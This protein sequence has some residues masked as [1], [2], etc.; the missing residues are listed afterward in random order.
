MRKESAAATAVRQDIPTPPAATRQEFSAQAIAQATQ[1]ATKAAVQAAVQAASQ[2]AAEAA[3]KAAAEAVSQ[4]TALVATQMAQVSRQVEEQLAEIR[5]QCAAMQL[6]HGATASEATAAKPPADHRQ[7]DE[8]PPTSQLVVPLG[9]YRRPA[10]FDEFSNNTTAAP[11]GSAVSNGSLNSSDVPLHATT[12]TTTQQQPRGSFSSHTTYT[13]RHK[14]Y[15]LPE[16]DGKPEDWPIFEAEFNQTTAEYGY[17]DAQN[18]SRLR[19]SLRG[20]AR[21]LVV[22]LLIRPDNVR[23]AM[24]TLER[25]F[26]K[27]Q[28]LVASQIRRVREIAP[29]DE[30]RL[31]QFVPFAAKVATM[32]AYFDTP[33]ARQHL[34]NPMIIEELLYKLPQRE[35]RE[36]GRISKELQPYPSLKDLSAWLDT[37][38]EEMSETTVQY[39][40][41]AARQRK[42]AAK[43]PRSSQ[44]LMLA[45]ST[46]AANQPRVCGMCKRNNHFT[47]ECYWLTHL[48]SDARWKAVKEKQLCGACLGEHDF[49]QCSNKKPCGI[50]GCRKQHHPILHNAPST[51]RNR[52]GPS[53]THRNPFSRPVTSMQSTS[54]AARTTNDTAA[55]HPGHSR[56]GNMQMQSRSTTPSPSTASTHAPVPSTSTSFN[57]HVRAAE[58]QVFFRLVPVKLFGPTRTIT[59]HAMLDEGS[60]VTLIDEDLAD[61]LGLDGPRQQLDL[62]WFGAKSASMDTRVVELRISGVCDNS[63]S[64]ALRNVYT[65]KRLL[66]PTQTVRVEELRSRYQTLRQLPIAEQ[67]CVQ[68]RLLI[69][70]DHCHLGV[71]HETSSSDQHGIVASRT[72]LGWVVY[73]QQ[74]RADRDVAVVLHAHLAHSLDDIQRTVHE[75]FTT[76]NFGVYRPTHDLLSDEEKYARLLLQQTTKRIGDRF[77]TGLLWKQTHAP[78]P[79]SRDMAMKRL[80]SVESKMR[81]DPVYAE[82]YRHQ[83]AENVR[84]GYAREMSDAEAAATSDRTWYLPHFAVINANKPGKFRLVFDAAA[85]TRGVSLNSTLSRGPDLHKPLPDVLFAFRVGV[86]AVCGDIKEMFSQIRIRADDQ[87]AQRYLW[88]NGDTS[89]PVRTFVM[90]SMTFGATCSPCSAHFVKNCNAEEHRHV[91]E[92]AVRHIVDRHYVDD[93]VASFSSAEKAIVVTNAVTA[94]HLKGGFELR[95]FISN[96]QRVQAAVGG[97][98]V[99]ATKETRDMQL[100]ATAT[101]K[102][103]GLFW[104]A[105]ADALVFRCAFTRV[106]PELLAGERR[107]TKREMLCMCMSVFDPFGMVANFMVG[108]KLLIQETWTHGVG[109]DDPIPDAIFERWTTWQR[110]LPNIATCSLPRCYT[111][112]LTTSDDVQLHIFADA[113]EL[114]FAAA[115]YWRVRRPDGEFD[116]A[117]VAGKTR[118]APQKLL[119]VPRLEL[120]AA[121]LAVRL[122]VTI[123]SAHELNVRTIYWSDSRTVVCWIRSHHRRYKPFV[124]H[125][126]AELLEDSSVEDWR[127]IPTGDNV[128]DDATRPVWPST[129]NAASRWLSGPAF[130]RHPVVD[131]P[132]EPNIAAEEE[133]PE[134]VKPRFALHA[135]AS[136]PLFSFDRSSDYVRLLRTVARV[137]R[138]VNNARKPQS[139]RS[140]GELQPDE[141]RAAEIVLCRQ[142]QNDVYA[143]E[144]DD[145][146]RDHS[147][148][149][150]S[151]IYKLQPYLDDNGVIRLCGRI[152]AASQLPVESRRPIILPNKHALTDLIVA[153]AHVRMR[154]QN[155]E[156]VVCALRERYWIVHART[157]VRRLKRECQRCKIVAA[158]PV[159]PQMGAL[160]AD[161]V[162]SAQRPFTYTG[163][164]YFGPVY[165]TVG[166][167]R[168]KRW[169]ALFTC[170]SIRAVHLELAADLTTDA[171]ILCIRNFVNTRGVPVRIR[172]DN[173]TNFVG[174]DRELRACVDAFD[175]DA[176]TRECSGRGIEWRFNCPSNP[177]AGGSWERL[178]RS[179][180]R[181]LA[182][183]I[184][185]T[186]PRVETMRSLLIEAAN[187]VNSRPLTH[188]PVSHDEEEPI[189]PNHFLLGGTSSTQTPGPLDPTAY[190]S[191]KQWRILQDMKNRFWHRWT[192]EY[193]PE[194]TRRTKWHEA[195]RPLAVGELVVICDD[196]M[197]RNQWPRGRVIEVFTGKDGQVR[198]A[199]VRTV[200][201]DLKRPACKL[202]V[203]DVAERA[204]GSENPMGL[205]TGGAVADAGALAPPLSCS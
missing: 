156:A 133:L 124:A 92:E 69:G 80:L 115:A 139:G 77:E 162:L 177:E 17:T 54:R 37:V 121:V 105:D 59:T 191:R 181:V 176:L 109:W 171:C 159:A 71:A 35:R 63:E 29:I 172:S 167:R 88:R 73:G 67:D 120:Q 19:K 204:K 141:L 68:P 183:T 44:F 10:P 79:P 154:H 132:K 32:V 138:F 160:P 123:R 127:W 60:S 158:R 95:R 205:V 140:N 186:A 102:V 168:E 131:W 164:D 31:D 87:D 148:A 47:T 12:T 180:K 16:F 34:F 125:R 78:L 157:A 82:S 151:S 118:C 72:K 197:P 134:Q 74:P 49:H 111:P 170:L 200:H 81:R 155:D 199:R 27:P 39:P 107:P 41:V 38:A 144:I 136:A 110:E 128:A 45:D 13:S 83:M 117:F 33:R 20:S 46:P 146:R 11:L 100:E 8:G 165:V 70:L 75:Y 5:R 36:W 185:E 145:L 173:G 101:D 103:L 153:N 53:R 187:I 25:Q 122:G 42:P 113:S 55:A 163:L 48:D 201:G 51:P 106:P 30:G 94:I 142:M 166:R 89:Q 182:V 194:L 112:W 150:R 129:F 7:F 86:V 66:L 152:D 4:V 175:Q 126:V 135:A 174:A 193:L 14:L 65:A 93:Y 15:D 97:P 40:D 143:E 28:Y 24:T 161:R 56:N 198:T 43:E 192:R 149:K 9:E 91:S 96:D 26:G 189:T 108:A 114:A 169:V 184:T 104:D 3:A 203:L 84:K 98:A 179:V 62:N 23:Q 99:A 6:G 130:L 61:D 52:Q 57:G 119:S 18:V 202:A 147:V 90:T 50:D 21:D 2:V 58:P 188:L 76:E 195:V 178:V 22:C 196:A 64:Y 190:C 1:A 85:E 116:V 137:M